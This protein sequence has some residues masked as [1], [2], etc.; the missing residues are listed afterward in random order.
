LDRA[1]KASEE[2]P[3]YANLQAVDTTVSRSGSFLL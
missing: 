2:I 3:L 1:A